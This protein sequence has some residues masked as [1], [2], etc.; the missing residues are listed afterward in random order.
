M[1]KKE[2]SEPVSEQQI[3]D[4]KGLNPG[5][6]PSWLRE[7]EWAEPGVVPGTGTHSHFC[8]TP[9][10]AALTMPHKNTRLL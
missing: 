3:A 9:P 6:A 7:G 2:T 5:R 4:F 1:S 10:P 8:P